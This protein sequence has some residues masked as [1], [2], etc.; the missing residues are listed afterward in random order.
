MI[1]K[2]TLRGNFIHFIRYN[3]FGK[4]ISQVTPVERLS[5]LPPLSWPTRKNF[6]IFCDKVTNRRLYMDHFGKFPT[7]T[8]LRFDEKKNELISQINKIV[9]MYIFQKKISKIVEMGMHNQFLFVFTGIVTTIGY[10]Y[11]MYNG[12]AGTTISSFFPCCVNVF[13]SKID[14]PSSLCKLLWDGFVLLSSR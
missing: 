9:K 12:A 8:I 14:P 7:P 3:W 11:V 5:I 4:R 1:H 2:I 13:Y 6:H 10:Q